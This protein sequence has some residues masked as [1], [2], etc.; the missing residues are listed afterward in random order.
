[1]SRRSRPP[2]GQ[3]F[4]H[5]RGVLERIAGSLPIATGR[6]VLEIGAGEG[7]LTEFLL[8]AGARV[9]AIEIDAELVERLR[10]RFGVA[11]ALAEGPVHD[12]TPEI[13]VPETEVLAS[14]PL[15]IVAGDV[16]ETDF[17]A[18]IAARSPERV[19]VAG[20]L[21]YY[22]TSPILRKMFGAAAQIEQAV[23]LMQR[24]VAARVTARKGSR[25]Y[26]FLSVLCRLY[27]EPEYLFDVRAGAFRPPPRVTSAV[28]R[29]TMRSG[30]KVDPA[31]VEFAKSCFSQPR[32]KMVN[33]LSG[34]YDRSLLGGFEQ[35][36]RR[37]Q[38]L[39]LE[40]LQE[41]FG[42]L[43]GAGKAG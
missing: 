10:G 4:L 21:P 31:F 42:V 19:L 37:A 5:D 22:I 39:D 11:G 3:H 25:D 9:T 27:S 30:P 15:E 17:S 40:E 13:G 20:N 43:E 14:G 12:T 26:G 41:F 28:V 16:L 34:R 24:E 33:N 23:F 2:R 1:M 35:S 8:A 32:K 6:R 7:A 18:L 38:Q 29:L 36:Q